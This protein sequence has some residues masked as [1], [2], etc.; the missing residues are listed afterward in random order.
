M[1]RRSSTKTSTSQPRFFIIVPRMSVPRRGRGNWEKICR[2]SACGSM[3]AI[4]GTAFLLGGGLPLLVLRQQG[5]DVLTRL[6]EQVAPALDA[7]LEELHLG[8]ETLDGLEQHGQP[9][10]HL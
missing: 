1:C 5:Q 3:K 4:L 6:L 8:E 9:L 2:F 10:L 7:F